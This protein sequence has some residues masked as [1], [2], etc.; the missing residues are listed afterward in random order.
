[1]PHPRWIHDTPFETALI[2]QLGA[3]NRPTLTAIIKATFEFLPNRDLV[4][5]ERQVPVRLAPEHEGDPECSPMVYDL[6]TVPFKPRGEILLAAEARAQSPVIRHR[7]GFQAGPIAKVLDVIGARHWEQNRLGTASS[8]PTPFTRLPI[9]YSLAFGGRDPRHQDGAGWPHNPLGKGVVDSAL[10]FLPNTPLPQIFQP[11]DDLSLY[12]M[13]VALAGFGPLAPNWLPRRDF[14]GTYDARWQAEVAPNF[15][16][17][18]RPEFF[19]SSPAD[20]QRSGYWEGD[21]SVSLVG[22]TD[23][24][25]VDFRLP[26]LGKPA[27]RLEPRRGPTLTVAHELDTVL[28]DTSARQ[29]ELIW[30]APFPVAVPLTAIRTL[31]SSFSAQAQERIQR[32]AV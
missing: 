6:E 29:I 4:I 22:M 2:P 28:I 15:P 8:M 20:Q 18:F 32:M 11:D 17:D 23:E 1:M 12:G 27:T 9:R 19:L 31:R 5:A 14:A 24:Y 3:D 16:A 30:R 26:A 21:E 7:V 13:Q 25:R 10:P